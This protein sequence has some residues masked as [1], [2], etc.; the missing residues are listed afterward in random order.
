MKSKLDD[1]IAPEIKD[2][3]FSNVLGQIAGDT[4]IKTLLEIG[5]SAGDGSTKALVESIKKRSDIDEVSLYCLEVSIPRFRELLSKY[6]HLP[7]F[8]GYNMSSIPLLDF[9]GEDE[10]IA[11][12]NSTDSNLRNY[13]LSDVL[14]WRKQDIEYL[15]NRKIVDDGIN[16][17]KRLASVRSFDF[18]LI[19]GS[20]FTGERELNQVIGARVIALDDVLCFKGFNAYQRLRGH[21]GYVLLHENMSCR[22]GFAVFGRQY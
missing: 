10:V 19:D 2:D 6:S 7:F 5:S 9:P 14:G 4:S 16:A 21:A 8:F 15:K 3:E 12:Y 1:L 20:E 13:P 17:I 18:V 11:F 22:N